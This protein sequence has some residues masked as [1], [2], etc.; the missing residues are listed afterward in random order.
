[1]IMVNGSLTTIE[2]GEQPIHHDRF[3]GESMG[4][5]PCVGAIITDG[6]ARLLLIKRGHEPGMG[7]WSLPGGRVEAGETDAAALVRE[8]REE[9][10]L[11][12]TPGPLVGVVDRPGLAGS[13]YR[14]RDYAA[15]VVGGTL[16]AGDDAADVRWTHPD[17]FEGLEL[18]AGLVECLTEWGV[19]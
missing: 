7:L 18:T 2:C 13:V 1:M 15:S 11:T 19:L 6:N 12:V 9:T 8:V 10:G 5:V 3:W 4:L 14:I 16:R 17:E